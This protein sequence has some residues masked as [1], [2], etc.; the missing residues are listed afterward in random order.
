[1]ARVHV[2]RDRGERVAHRVE[3]VHSSLGLIET[4]KPNATVR[5]LLPAEGQRPAIVRPKD[6]VAV[7][8]R[9]VV[10]EDVLDRDEVAERLR[11]LLAVDLEEA[12][13]H[14]EARELL[15]AAR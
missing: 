8:L 2:A 5:E 13:V 1:F 11:H 15:P 12:P 14:P 4:G 10:I 3:V 6:E 9:I 7:A